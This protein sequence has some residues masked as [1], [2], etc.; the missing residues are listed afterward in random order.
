M[1]ITQILRDK[2]FGEAEVSVISSVFEGILHEMHLAR[3]D[4]I[5]KIIAKNVIRFAEAG[6]RDPTR[7]RERA[8]EFLRE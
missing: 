3:T 1:P 7:L 6:E 5:A 4:P 2:S 8:T